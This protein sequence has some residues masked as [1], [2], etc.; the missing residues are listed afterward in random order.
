MYPG[1]ITSVLLAVKGYGPTPSWLRPKTH[2][3]ARC[4]TP[5]D[6]L[7]LAGDGGINFLGLTKEI[8]QMRGTQQAALA[9]DAP[10]EERRAGA[11]LAHPDAVEQIGG[12]G[13]LQIGLSR[14]R[15]IE[16][17]HGRL[18]AIQ[19]NFGS[20]VTQN[21]TND[22][23]AVGKG[24]ELLRLGI[25]ARK[26]AVKHI[27]KLLIRGKNGHTPTYRSFRYSISSGHY[28]RWLDWVQALGEGGI[29]HSIEAGE[30]P[31]HCVFPWGRGIAG[32]LLPGYNV[33]RG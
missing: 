11:L 28:T 15:A 30:Y 31:V 26:D 2:S 6:Q 7:V 5:L 22:Q 13:K 18:A 17:L 29:L 16:D 25:E 19:Q 1:I 27:I 4:K 32:W 20:R 23:V 21:D 33:C 10:A 8:Y 14:T 3:K 9:F 12:H 24:R